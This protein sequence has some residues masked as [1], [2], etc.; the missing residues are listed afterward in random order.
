MRFKLATNVFGALA[1]IGGEFLERISV[2]VYCAKVQDVWWRE[3]AP[4]K[5]LL[6]DDNVVSVSLVGAHH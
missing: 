4:I 5:F 6:A 1:I 2:S 3:A